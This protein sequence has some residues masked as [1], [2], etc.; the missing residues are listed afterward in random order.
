MV[1][2]TDKETVKS[3]FSTE[4]MSG[5][6]GGYL[7]YENNAG[8]QRYLGVW[9]DRKVGKFLRMLRE[10]GAL[11]EKAEAA[12]GQFRQRHRAAR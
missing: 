4:E 1:G 6:F 10:R 11:I 2:F 5:L 12:P 9:G 3:L 7:E 8:S